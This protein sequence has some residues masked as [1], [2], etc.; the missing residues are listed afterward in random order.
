MTQ[1]TKKLAAA[2]ARDDEREAAGMHADDRLT[3][4]THQ[5]W[6]D[7]CADQHRSVTAGRLLAEAREIDRARNR[8]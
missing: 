6:A 7:D 3:C 8:A 1:M 4:H 5:A 2:L